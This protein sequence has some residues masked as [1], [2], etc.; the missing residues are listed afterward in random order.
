VVASKGF[1][2]GLGVTPLASGNPIIFTAEDILSSHTALTIAARTGTDC[3][4]WTPPYPLVGSGKRASYTIS[5]H[6]LWMI[7][8]N[9]HLVD[10]YL[11]T[12]RRGIPYPG[13]YSVCSKSVH[14]WGPYDG[15]TIERWFRGVNAP[16]WAR[17]VSMEV[18]DGTVV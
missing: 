11:V 5:S 13:T 10:T 18:H 14:A 17:L 12:G 9:E 1:P 15:L 2:D 16:P 6:R 7:D 8:E 4:V 3:E